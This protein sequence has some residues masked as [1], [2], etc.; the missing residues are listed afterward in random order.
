MFSKRPAIMWILTL[1]LVL[2]A[3]AA[4]AAAPTVAGVSVSPGLVV[5]AETITFRVT[6]SEDVTGVTPANFTIGVVSTQPQEPA[7]TTPLTTPQVTSISGSGTTYDVSVDCHN[8]EGVIRLNISKANIKNGANEAMAADAVFGDVDIDNV[9]PKI[10]S[11]TRASG[12]PDPTVKNPRFIVTFDEKVDFGAGDIVVSGSAFTGAKVFTVSPSGGRNS[13]YTVELLSM[14]QSG[15]V[16]IDIASGVADDRLGNTNNEGYITPSPGAWEYYRDNCNIMT[17]GIVPHITRILGNRYQTNCVSPDPS[18]LT[19]LIELKPHQSSDS[20]YGVALVNEIPGNPPSPE[21]FD[22]SDVD[23]KTYDAANGNLVDTSAIMNKYLVELTPYDKTR[24]NL[25]IDGL[26][27]SYAVVVNI[28]DDAFQN[29]NANTT[30]YGMWNLSTDNNPPNLNY[31]EVNNHFPLRIQ[32]L[33]T[34]W[35]WYDLDRPTL[36]INKAQ[37]QDDP[38]AAPSGV[39]RFIATFNERMWGNNG[40][41]AADVQLSGTAGADTVEVTEIQ[42]QASVPT[43]FS[44]TLPDKGYKDQRTYNIVVSGMKVK[45]TVIADIAAYKAQ[46]WAANYN[47]HATSTDNVVEYDPAPSVTINQATDQTDPAC[48]N[49]INFIAEFSKPITGFTAGDV[50]LEGTAGAST[51]VIS[52][53]APFNGTMFNVAAGGMT[54]SGTVIVSIPAN[55]AKDSN[56]NFNYASTSTDATVLYDNVLPTVTINQATGQADPAHS[57]TVRFTVTFSEPVVGFEWVTDDTSRQDVKITGDAG[58]NTAVITKT[59]DRTYDV[60]V[61]GMTVTGS[62]I[63]NIPR[64]TVTDVAG[65]INEVATYTDNEVTFVT[66]LTLTLEQATTQKDPSNVLPIHFTAVF[67]RAVNDFIASD[68]TLNGTA[69]PTIA[70]ITDSGDHKTYDIAVSGVSGSGTVIVSL[71]AAIAHDQ[72]GLTNEASTSVDNQVV[73]ADVIVTATINQAAAQADPASASPINFTA[74]FSEAIKGFIGSDVVITGTAPGTKIATITGSGTTY[75]VAVSGMTGPGTVIVDIPAGAVETVADGYLNIASTSTDNTVSFDNVKPTV[76]IDQKA[77]QADPTTTLP[78][79]YTVVFSRDVVDFTDSAVILQSTNGD[80]LTATVTGSGTTYNVA[81]DGALS[82]TIITASIAAGAVHDVVGNTNPASTSTDNSITFDDQIPLDVTVEQAAGQSDPTNASTINFTAQFNKIVIDFTADDVTVNSTAG[83]TTTVVTDSGDHK[84]F[85]IAISGMTSVGTV[86]ASIAADVVHDPAGNANNESTSVDNTVT[87]DNIVPT[88]TIDQAIGQADPTTTQPVNFS[89]EFSENVT[90]FT[91]DSVTLVASSGETLVGV[92]TGSGRSYNVAVSGATTST[93]ITATIAE[94]AVHDVSGNGNAASTSTDN[95]VIW[96]DGIPF[97]VTVEQAAGQADPTNAGVVNFTVTFNKPVA[98]ILG[99]TVPISGT[100][101]ATVAVPTD[102]GDHKEFNVAVSGMTQTGTVILTVPAGFAEDA[103]GNQN[104]ASTSVDNIV[105]YDVAPVAVTINQAA[106]QYDPTN[107]KA[108]NFTAVFSKVVADFTGANVTITG[109]AGASAATVTDSGNHKTFN[110]AVTGMTGDGDVVASILAGVVHDALGNTN[111][112]STSTDNSVTIDSTPNAVTVE[113]ATAQI[114]PTNKTTIDFTVVFSR[115]VVAFVPANVTVSGT[116]GGTKTVTI[117]GTGTTFNV[118]VSGMTTTGTVV[119]SIA[120]DKVFD[121]VE[122]GNAAS[123]SEDN[124]VTYDITKPVVKVTFPTTEASCT[125]NT[126]T[127][128]FSGTAT[129]NAGIDSVVWAD[130]NGGTG[131]CTGTDAWSAT[132]ITIDG[133]SETVTVTA[134]DKAGNTASTTLKVDIISAA[135]GAAWTGLAMV[136]VPL[137]PDTK[138]PK[139]IVGFRNNDWSAYLTANGVYATY[140]SAASWFDPQASTPG[141]GFW[142]FFESAKA[143]TGTILDQSKT[144]KVHLYR[145]WN[146]IGHPYI[147]AVKWDLNA[148]QISYGSSVLSLGEAANVGYV[149]GY[150]WGWRPDST[151]AARGEYFLVYDS[152]IIEGVV[153]NMQPWQA[154]WIRSTVECDME[155]PGLIQSTAVKDNSILEESE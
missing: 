154:Y 20:D 118:R 63:V 111:T 2:Y 124:T 54:S 30:N 103:F 23:V 119:L 5:T 26:D 62:V 106:T 134:T 128:F 91:D 56:D 86:E 150:A 83:S 49:P 69:T 37:D 115:D 31:P 59:G 108:V 74:N 155:F 15:R 57:D 142:A 51:V 32:C 113:Q 3:G 84:Q 129:D 67:D 126:R 123:T 47:I 141:R 120:A 21:G 55:I 96:E 143:P 52:E 122:I 148:I 44:D 95:T 147:S 79:N 82:A 139:P 17:F 105:T 70:V 14:Q 104:E 146:L 13:V 71:G 99:D 75:N 121:S 87:Y 152:S 88:V 61:S 137:I 116:A 125:R 25:E 42:N 41:S 66:P 135:P 100:A 33:R 29:N 133:T 27:K 110:V 109:T 6:F 50:V 16:K 28:P 1:M 94:N 7:R 114:D 40:F 4:N 10:A 85:N 107:A 65:N 58:A 73:Y 22:V 92:V 78:V 112:A 102:S 80:T 36:T 151:L 89:V 9:H 76:T 77:G 39:I 127:L 43:L 101:G 93:I 24:W 38:T 72:Y 153:D 98:N 117:S 18:R 132:G 34:N 8:F 97:M 48:N 45:G 46:D 64:D 90:D 140:P 68:V 19:F 12:Q 53:L 130:E 81:V 60:A 35:L 138:D 149:A 144:A 136:T 145:G 131:T 11:I